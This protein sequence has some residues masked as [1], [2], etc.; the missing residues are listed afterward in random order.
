MKQP[1]ILMEALDFILAFL[2]CTIVPIVFIFGAFIWYVPLYPF[3]LFGRA[4]LRANR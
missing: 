3:R 2:F 1:S 4:F